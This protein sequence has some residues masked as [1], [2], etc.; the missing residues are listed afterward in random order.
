M[1]RSGRPIVNWH[2]VSRPLRNSS[3]KGG[4]ETKIAQTERSTKR[5]TKFL[6][7]CFRGAVYLSEDSNFLFD[8]GNAFAVVPERF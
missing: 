7:F 3:R 6:S 1:K 5:K 8:F 4:S 2:T